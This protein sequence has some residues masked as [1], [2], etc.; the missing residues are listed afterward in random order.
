[1]ILFV[2]VLS[3]LLI[4]NSWVLLGTVSIL[5]VSKSFSDSAFRFQF[6]KFPPEPDRLGVAH[7]HTM[8]FPTPRRLHHLSSLAL[9]SVIIAFTLL[10]QLIVL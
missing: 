3:F 4:N 2:K 8:L 6:D 1:M 7:A 9:L 10:L 5:I